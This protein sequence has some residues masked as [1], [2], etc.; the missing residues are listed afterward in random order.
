MKN[1]KR[2]LDIKSARLCVFVC[3]YMRT[4]CVV[5]PSFNKIRIIRIIMTITTT[6]IKLTPNMMLIIINHNK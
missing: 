6:I 2:I 3:M 5:H 1:A 4:M